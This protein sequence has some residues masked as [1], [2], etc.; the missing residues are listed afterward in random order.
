MGKGKNGD[1]SKR[2]TVGEVDRI[3]ELRLTVAMSFKA[4]AAEVGCDKNTVENQ[5]NKY[6]DASA[7]RRN[8][9]PDR[10]RADLLERLNTTAVDARQN[11]ARVRNAMDDPDA[12]AKAEARYMAEETKALL[13]LSRVGGYDAPIKLGV[14][15]SPMSDAEADR[16]LAEL[17][18]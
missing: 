3:I 18:D 5:W 2:L 13:A 1:E 11:R 6:L 9:A 16:I 17:D 10:Y 12:L 15:F 4:I 14:Q 7:A 8:E